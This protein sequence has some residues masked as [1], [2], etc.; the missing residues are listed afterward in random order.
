MWQTGPEEVTT[1]EGEVTN[2]SDGSKRWPKPVH[3]WERFTDPRRQLLADTGPEVA[4][5]KEKN[6]GIVPLVTNCPTCIVTN[7]DK[8]IYFIQVLHKANKIINDNTHILHNESVFL[9]SSR[10][11]RTIIFKTN[12]KRDSFIP[13]SVQL[14]N[15]KYQVPLMLCV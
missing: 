11:F 3:H 5:V 9:P 2:L 7:R 1:R 13:M 10:R 8:G 15:D 14:L 6:C 12:R 4:M